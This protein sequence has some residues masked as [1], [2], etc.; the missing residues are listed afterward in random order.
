MEPLSRKLLF[1]LSEADA[2]DAFD[3]ADFSPEELFALTQD[4]QARFADRYKSFY[5]D[6]KTDKKLHKEDW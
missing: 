1:K 2:E 6:I 3:P 5:D 4:G